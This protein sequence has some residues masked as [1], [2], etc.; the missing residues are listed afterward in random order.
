MNFVMPTNDQPCDNKCRKY[1]YKD[2][3]MEV[4]S[5]NSDENPS[6]PSKQRKNTVEYANFITNKKHG[7]YQLV[8]KFPFARE[9]FVSIS[10]LLVL[11][12]GYFKMANIATNTNVATAHLKN[13][14]VGQV[15]N[16][17]VKQ[18]YI[19]QNDKSIEEKGF[20]RVETLAIDF[21]DNGTQIKWKNQIRTK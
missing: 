11:A 6:S 5:F 12:N 3:L 13:N 18:T 19:L 10:L 21:F 4:S 14:G 7:K 1:G 9:T 8:F 16:Y 15:Y 17:S 20:E 2:D